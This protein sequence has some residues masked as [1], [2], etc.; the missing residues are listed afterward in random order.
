MRFLSACVAAVGLL[1]LAVPV[2][3]EP[4][5]VGYYASWKQQQSANVDF[6]K[7]THIN[8]A[9]GIPNSDGTFTF[10][11]TLNI[12]NIVTEIHGKGAK[13]LVSIGGWSGSNLISTILKDETANQ[14]FITSIVDYV[15]ANE[16][17]GV[18]LDW[19]YPGR[20][21]AKCNVVDEANDTPN[22]LKFVQALREQFNTEFGESKKL[23]TMAVY[24][25][26]FYINGAPSTDVSEFAKVVDFINLMQYD[27]NG[28]WLNNTGPNAPLEFEQGKGA[29]FSFASA[30][31]AWTKAGWPANQLTAGLAFYGRSTTATV[32]MTKDPTNQ[33]Q[34]Q[35]SVLPK[36]DS[37]DAE[38]SDTCDQTS[39][40][41]GMW[42]WKHLRDQGVLTSPDTAASPWVRQWDDTTKTPWL[43]NP[44][45]KIFIS[46]DDIE[47]IGAKIEYASSKGLA[48]AMVW[49]VYMDYEDELL[50]TILKWPSGGGTVGGINNDPDDASDK[51][52]DGKTEDGE[53]EDGETEDGETEDG[54]T[55]D[56]ETDNGEVNGFGGTGTGGDSD[57]F[58]FGSQND[59]D[60]KKGD[61]CSSDG[62]M[63]CEDS[64]NSANYYICLFGE[65]ISLACSSGTVC[66][67]NEGSIIC[68]WEETAAEE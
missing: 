7:Y 10:D 57:I 60:V 26:P 56:G 59:K 38:W 45:T 11:E 30:I 28:A 31:D 51:A 3:G 62:E 49:A 53:T 5:V 21:G 48:G 66:V 14:K 9:F 46:Y 23:I 37:E 12:P 39:G 35:G 22:Y 32:D 41:S 67:E 40:M 24:V 55:E 50:D 61:S 34:P 15:K 54:E 29:Q 42:Q 4:I 27:I 63:T 68:S 8:L 65:K 1:Y 52:T 6:S 17:D 2:F 25:Q 44:E 47:S 43:F 13:A 64:G 20:Q 36:G 19:E 58:Q 33:Y 16:L 18:D